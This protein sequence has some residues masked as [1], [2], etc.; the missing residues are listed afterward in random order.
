MCSGVYVHDSLPYSHFESKTKKI[1]G[2]NVRR[3][4]RAANLSQERLS[5][6]SDLH[7]SS[8]GRLERGVLN[9]TLD[10]LEQIALALNVTPDELL[11]NDT[12]PSN[13]KQVSVM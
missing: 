9:I 3:L 8:I 10:T 12:F 1:T 2:E 7:P 4:R 5:E 6:I 13:D 11:Q